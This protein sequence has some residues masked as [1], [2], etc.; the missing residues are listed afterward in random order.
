[1]QFLSWVVV[2]TLNVFVLG[3]SMEDIR[4]YESRM[5]TETNKKVGATESE[6]AATEGE[7]PDGMVKE[8]LAAVPLTPTN[9][10]IDKRAPI[11]L[12]SDDNAST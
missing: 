9:T 1:M 4:K 7:H 8:R 10:P 12:F 11:S 6:N 3:M 2:K 5:H